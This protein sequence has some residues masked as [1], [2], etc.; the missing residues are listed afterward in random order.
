MEFGVNELDLWGAG[1]SVDS[2]RSVAKHWGK[3]SSGEAAKTEAVRKG[4]LLRGKVSQGRPHPLRHSV[5]GEGQRLDKKKRK[6]SV[7]LSVAFFSRKS[8][9][10][11]GTALFLV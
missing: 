8:V 7:E 10:N 3:R 2:E 11:D 6:L 4:E 1:K 5:K 9:R